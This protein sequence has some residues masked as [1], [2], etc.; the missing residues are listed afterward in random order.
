[1]RK[2]LLWILIGGVALGA[3][4]CASS[5]T[6][7]KSSAPPASNVTGRWTGTYVFQPSSAG[8][9]LATVNF[10]QNGNKVQG[11][12]DV[13]G[14]HQYQAAVI[15]G[16]MSGNDIQIIGPDITGWMK[17]NGNEMTGLINGVLPAQV[18]LRKVQ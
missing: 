10:T 7:T 18:A 11:N 13:Q 15:N 14:P 9:G 5:G 17:V 6:S 4:A 12:L 8:N 2:L 1:M 3:A 16:I